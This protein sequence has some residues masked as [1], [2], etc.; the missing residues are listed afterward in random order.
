MNRLFLFDEFN[1][2]FKRSN[3]QQEIREMQRFFEAYLVAL[4]AAR[5]KI[6]CFS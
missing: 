4:Y 3:I 5:V 1:E 6:L 2:L